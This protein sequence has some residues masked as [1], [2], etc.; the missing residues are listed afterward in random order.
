M[1]VAYVPSYFAVRK[2]SVSPE[3]CAVR[4]T[5]LPVPSGGTPGPVWKPWSGVRNGAFTSGSLQSYAC[6]TQWVDAVDGSV[7][8]LVTVMR[9]VSSG[10]IV[11]ASAGVATSIAAAMGPA[12]VPAHAERRRAEDMEIDLRVLGESA[13]SSAGFGHQYTYRAPISHGFN[14]K[15]S[16][17]AMNH[18]VA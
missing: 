1:S 14:P 7:L 5:W 9:V 11:P 16:R 3:N 13:G 17:T 6:S 12:T 4:I 10:A 8:A 2:S 18:D 15:I